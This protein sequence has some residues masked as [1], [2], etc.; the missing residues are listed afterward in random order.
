MVS[1]AQIPAEAKNSAKGS[2]GRL[3]SFVAAGFFMSAFSTACAA[4]DLTIT[5]DNLRNNS[6]QVFLC[7]FSAE[8]SLSALFPDC[9]RGN[10]AQSVRLPIQ[11]GKATV[12]FKGLKDGTY[13]VAM[14]HDENNN[15]E[16]D[17]NLLGI[18]TEGLGVSNNPRLMGKPNFSE[19]QFAV[20]GNT[21]I[22]IQAKYFL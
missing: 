19:A 20:K 14:I 6:G 13:A 11:A 1:A 22:S 21:S 17:T 16:L 8:S 4:S 5:I 2:S 10:P 9:A 18:P 12:T 7:V 15:G 3:F